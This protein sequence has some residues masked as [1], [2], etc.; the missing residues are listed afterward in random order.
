M[1]I[2]RTGVSTAA[3]AAALALDLLAQIHEPSAPEALIYGAHL[4]RLSADDVSVYNRFLKDQRDAATRE[5][6][7]IPLDAAAFVIHGIELCAAASTSARPSVT[8]DIAAACS[9]LTAAA[10]AIL[11]C[12]DVNL[13]AVASDPS[14]A[15]VRKARARLTIP[16]TP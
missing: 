5:T 15:D 12:V 3:E 7:A 1:P 14:F 2:G 8:A 10:H 4:R 11:N 6:I 16:T 13:H 9:L